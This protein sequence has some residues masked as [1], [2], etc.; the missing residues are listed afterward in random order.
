MKH[1][2]FLMLSLFLLSQALST[3]QEGTKIPFNKGVLKICSSKNFIIKGYDGN[4]VIIKNLHN[5]VE[6]RI[7][8]TNLQ[9]SKVK[10]TPSA[11]INLDSTY[12]AYVGLLR[13]AK[14]VDQS[15]GL[16]KLGKKAAT[17]DSGIYLIIEQTGDELIIKDD[18]ENLF[19]MTSGEKYE[20]TIPNS[21]RLNW[22]TSGCTK[23]RSYFLNSNPSEIKNFKGEVEISSLLSNFILI[24]VSGPVS[25]NTIGGNVTVKFD[26][27]IPNH[28]YSI[29]S[30]NGF[31][32]ITLPKLSNLLVYATASEILSDLDFTIISEEENSRTQKMSLKLGSGKVKMKL[33]ANLGN[34]YLR[35]Q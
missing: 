10:N 3:A 19:V 32:D 20:I 29:Y 13:S 23:S 33:D 22:D 2:T 18:M 11:D 15:K 14:N 34:I 9:R 12:V 21:I 24:D 7:L 35:K 4:E 8:Y 5:V 28:L 17:K 6:D 16:K 30:N 1:I 27:T 31:I 25:I 26:K